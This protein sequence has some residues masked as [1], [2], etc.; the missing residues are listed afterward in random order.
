LIARAAGPFGKFSK[1]MR[2]RADQIVV[3][4]R[5]NFTKDETLRANVSAAQ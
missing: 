2:Q 4:S 1:A 3:V 5:F